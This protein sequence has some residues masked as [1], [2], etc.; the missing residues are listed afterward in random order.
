MTSQN[1]NIP[2]PLEGIRVI[3]M[4]IVWAGPYATM[5][6]SDMGAEVIRVES[7]QTP[8]I[9]TRGNP[10]PPKGLL[11]TP[12]ANM[13]P[14]RD[15]GKRPWERGASFAYSGRNKR[16]L[17]ADLLRDEGR[18]VFFRLAKVSDVFIENGAAGT[19]EK[20]GI[21][22][23]ALKEINPKLIMCSLPGY[24]TNGPYKYYKG[25]GANVEAVCGHT[26]LRG[27]PD[28]DFTGTS[29]IFHADPAAGGT[30][31]FLILSALINRR[32]TGKGQYVNLSQAE[33]MIT[34]LP[35]AFM[36]YSMNGRVRERM[37]NR[38]NKHTQGCYPCIGE[39]NWVV[40]TKRNN[41]EWESLCKAMGKPELIDD[42]RFNDMRKRIENHNDI[43]QIIS[44][45][46]KDKEKYEI[47]RTLQ[48][49][50][51]PAGPVTQ[52]NDVLTDPHNIDR[53][54]Y[55]EHFHP[56]L[57]GSFK[58]PGPMFKMSE[59]PLRIR[60]LYPTLG[61]DNEY[62]YKEL[63]GYSDEE[64]SKLQEQKHIGDTYFG[65]GLEDLSG[66]IV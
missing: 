63:L 29:P 45:W 64:Y 19:V 41:Q 47:F 52:P 25:Y 11:G 56:S 32:K 23:E 8:D 66:N 13:F 48:S 16:S 46:T 62:I 27:Y 4:T 58:Y 55:E 10:K 9:N 28:M 22:Y 2:L 51:I 21:T 43:D 6:F 38:H 26:Y 20:L 65:L 30:A 24:G 54:L 57:E 44:E 39:D 40:M 59:T 17:T 49:L 53:G 14:N 1:N 34:Q 42:S 37:G 3:D 7:L 35:Q 33:N 15:P 50:G 12:R 5:L 18:E 36:D 60:K 31:A 61:E